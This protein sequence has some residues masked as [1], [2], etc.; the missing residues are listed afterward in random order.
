MQI[1][2]VIF[3]IIK[4]KSV[5]KKLINSSFVRYEKFKLLKSLKSS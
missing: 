5:Y 2:I 4:N 3:C 1:Q